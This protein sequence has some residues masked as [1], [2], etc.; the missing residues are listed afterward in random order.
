MLGPSALALPGKHVYARANNPSLVQQAV[1]QV[2][3]PEFAEAHASGSQPDCVSS[4]RLVDFIRLDGCLLPSCWSRRNSQPPLIVDGEQVRWPKAKGMTIAAARAH[5]RACPGS[6]DRS[7]G[8]RKVVSADELLPDLDIKKNRVRLC[9]KLRRPVL[10]P[11][12][13][14]F[15]VCGLEPCRCGVCDRLIVVSVPCIG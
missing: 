14:E 10:G 5:I 2:G 11:D 15:R 7:F 9:Y 4:I 13:Q 12:G 8:L 6:A 1:Q 3:K